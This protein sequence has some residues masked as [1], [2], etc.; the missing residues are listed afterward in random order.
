MAEL[1]TGT[2]TL[3]FTDIEGSTRLLER[4]GNRYL[5][6]LGEHRRVLR[7]AF[8]QH[9]GHEVGAEGDALF[10]AFTGAHDAVAAAV[11]GQ[12]A[13]ANHPWPDEVVL[14]VRMGIHTGEPIADAGDYAGLDVHRAARICAAGHGGQ[15]LCSQTTRELLGAELPS[16]IELRDLGEYRLKDLTGSQRIFQVVIPGLPAD[17]PALRTLGPHPVNL[18]VQLTRFVGRER[19]LARLHELLNDPACRLVTLVGPGGIGKTRLAVQV[20][21]TRQDRHRDGVVFVSLVGTAPARP[22][23]AGDLVVVNLAR[24]L[25]VSL[26]VQRD[27]LE[28]LADHLTA[29]ELLL[30]LDNLEQLQAAAEVVTTLLQRAPGLQV[31]ITSRRRLGVDAEWLV[32]VTGLPYPQSEDTDLHNYEAVQL[33]ED[34]ARLIRPDF[35]PA[36]EVDVARICRLVAGVPLAIELAARWMRSTTPA[37]IADRLASGLDLLATNAPDVE[38]RHQSLRSV[39]D[40]SWQLLTD[41]ERRVLARL[42]VL[43]GGFDLDAAAVVA[44][45]TLPLLAGLADHS[46]IEVAEDGRYAIHELLRQYAAERLAVDPAAEQTTRERHAKHYAGLLPDPSDEPAGDEGKLDAEIENLRA[47]TDWLIGH[48]SPTALDAHLGR[49]WPFYRRKGW[50]RETQAV[51]TAALDRSDIPILEQARWHR[52][53]GEAHQQLGETGS[54]RQHF[55]QTLALLGSSVPASALGWLDVLA[56]QALHRRLLPL[57]PG[58]PVE[59]REDRCADAAERAATCWQLTEVYWVLEDRFGLLAIPLFGL[60]QAERAGRLDLVARNQV[61]LGMILGTAG[62][63]RVGR[64]QVRSAVDAADRA[65]DPVTICW[66]QLASSLHSLGFGD[67]TMLEARAP[68]ALKLGAEAKLH[69]LADDV[70]MIIAI[71]RY[72]TGRFDDATAMAADARAAAQDRHDPVLQFWALLVLLETRLR[73]D[74]RDQ[75]IAEWIEESEDLMRQNVASIDVVR[76]HVAAARFHLAG[77]RAADAW[78]AI[79]AAA[80]LAGPEPSFTQYTLEAHAGIPEISLALLEQ[81]EPAGVDP[82]E[83]RATAASGLRRLRRYARSFPMARP[84]MLT[85]LGWSHWLKGRHGAAQ[86]A[87]ARATQEAERLGMPWELANAHYE[88]GRHLAA[89]E[90]SPL[91][92]GRTE[93]LDR[94]RSIFQALGCRSYTMASTGAG[95]I[96]SVLQGD[97]D[98]GP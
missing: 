39:I 22:E 62:L 70:V 89:G 57:R 33:F 8:A 2:V 98:R 78:R 50:F 73:T 49:L 83:L 45:A 28:L 46:L 61:V 77:G 80:H 26:A 10:V 54:A 6:V 55:E 25:G 40:W 17:F 14:R 66:T 35:H 76:A 79:H 93:H 74:A 20:A 12:R 4:L 24:A 94:A 87:W 42:S 67:W 82:G 37:V 65:G 75:V 58:G 47:A 86:R 31:L 44:D 1:P 85:C 18:P 21:A 81:H 3:L 19:E 41:E 84:R 32:E 53:L 59:R 71:G 63:R 51:L 34:R 23:E 60:N 88:L 13:L 68:K 56:S 91:G 9:N 95:T 16:G 48:A 72:W 69:R 7:A 36:N 27:P 5:G 11:T 29:R 90:H 52:L 97:R 96:G 15:I 38:R 92:L 30:V 43:R 64:R